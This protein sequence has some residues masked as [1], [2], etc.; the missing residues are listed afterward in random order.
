MVSSLFFFSLAEVERAWQCCPCSKHRPPLTVVWAPAMA[1]GAFACVAAAPRRAA[2]GGENLLEV[3]ARSRAAVDAIL[4]M[5]KELNLVV[6][7]GRLDKPFRDIDPRL[8]DV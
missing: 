4:D 6:S 7:H 1:M 2:E 5:G 3:E 8:F